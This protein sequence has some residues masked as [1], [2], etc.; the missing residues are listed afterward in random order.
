MAFST[1]DIIGF[2][3]M[4]QC[5]FFVVVLWSNRK[6]KPFFIK[7]LLSICACIAIHFGYLI[8]GERL[9]SSGNW[10][11][12]FFGLLYG[13]LYFHFAKSLIYRNEKPQ[14]MIWHYI[15]A[16]FTLGVVVFLRNKL[17]SYLDIV[18]VVITAHLAFYLFAILV[19][20]FRFRS[21]LKT[22][23][24]NYIEIDLKWLEIAI[25][26]QL[27]A[28]FTALLEGFLPVTNNGDFLVFLV[29]ALVLVLVNCLYYFGLKHVGL[30]KGLQATDLEG[31]ASEFTLDA[32]QYNEQK[33]ILA[34]YIETEKPYLEFD[35][36]LG[37]MALHTEISSRNLS[38]IINKAYGCNF[39]EF[40]NNRRLEVAKQLLCTTDKQVKEIMYESGFSNKTTFNTFFKK[41]TG[42]TP[43]QFRNSF[44]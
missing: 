23:L 18:S 11:G 9:F 40:I 29:Y 3:I 16:I 8:L 30:F 20:I 14:Q 13:P 38:Y 27:A 1:T 39:Y 22:T 25:Y 44:K 21:K 10:L 31:N 36:S 35:V 5:L 4:Y 7:M 17:W 37:Q 42:K 12:P 43:S 24:A 2:L 26:V 41:Q 32:A 6:T 15:P 34:A 19:L 33:D 28:I